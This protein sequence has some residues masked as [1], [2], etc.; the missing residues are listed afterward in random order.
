MKT[1]NELHPVFNYIL[2]CIEHEGTNEEKL[3][4]VLNAFNSEFNFEQNKKRYP[5]LQTRFAEWLQGAPSLFEIEYWNDGII[6]L[7]KEWQ[8]IPQDATEK[9]EQKILDNYYNFMACKFFQLCTQNKV[10]YSNL[11]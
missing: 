7:A 8:S 10:S 4:E 5:N 9:Q 6:N 1:N 11:Y 3:K 2:G